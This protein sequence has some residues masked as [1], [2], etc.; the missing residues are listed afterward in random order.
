MQKECMAHNPIH[1]SDANKVKIHDKLT[2][3]I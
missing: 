1:L 2:S 3:F